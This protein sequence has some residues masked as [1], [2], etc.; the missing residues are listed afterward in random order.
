[1][2]RDG[3]EGIRHGRLV[4]DDVGPGGVVRVVEGNGGELL[5]R[6]RGR[7]DRDMVGADRLHTLMVETEAVEAERVVEVVVGVGVV[8]EENPGG[9]ASMVLK[10]TARVMAATCSR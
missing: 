2:A 3:R 1:M 7:V 10:S 6:G 9:P 5:D 4:I 8:V